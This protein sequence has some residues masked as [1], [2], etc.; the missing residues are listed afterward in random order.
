MGDRESLSLSPD[1]F[2]RLGYAVID[3]LAG[4]LEALDGLMPVAPADSEWSHGKIPPCPDGPSDPLAALEYLF[5]EIL[6][7]GQFGNHPRFFARIPGP[8]NP[9]SVLADLAGV[10]VNAFAGS[11]TGGAGVSALELAVLGWLRD[12]MGLPLLTEGVLLSGGSEGTLTALAAAAHDR[13]DDRRAATAYVS[14]HTHASVSR[15]WRVLG[16]EP[17]HLRVLR[18]DTAHR[19]SVAAVEA[20]VALDREAGLEP[21]CVVATAGNTSTGAVDPL[22]DLATVCAREGLWFHIDG[23]YGAPAR[24]TPRGHDLLTGIERADSLVLDPHK[25]LFQPYEIGAVLV[26]EPGLL[27]RTFALEGGVYLRDTDGGTVEF[28]DRSPQLTRSSRALKLWLSL[29]AFGLD[30]FRAAIAH[31]MA[32]AEHAEALLRERGGWE[33]VSPATLAIVCFR[34]AGHDDEQTD[35]MVRATVAD[36]YAAP[37]TTVLDGH[38]VARLCTIN[39]RTTE[40]DILGTIERLER[41]AR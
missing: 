22:A 36:G 10:G 3:R 29:Q 7:R 18:P 38:T 21:F 2:R 23:A 19:L 1:E 32:L 25:W 33:I 30:A 11:W 41:F 35:A 39:P 9:L 28:R 37:S 20:A 14:G 4:H 40:T 27:E 16:F 17:A 8:S 12:W 26:R 6:P 24:L 15:A 31:G 34:R 13:A 5:D